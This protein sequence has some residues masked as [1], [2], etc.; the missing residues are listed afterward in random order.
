MIKG[1]R[2]LNYPLKSST[3]S[4]FRVYEALEMTNSNHD[5]VKRNNTNP[6]PKKSNNEIIEEN[7]QAILSGIGDLI[8][9]QNKDLDIIWVNQ[10]VSDLWGDVIGK[11]CY[12]VYK[13]LSEP[14]TDCYV[15][16]I[17]K[18]G[19]S[20]V[21]ERS[22]VLPDGRC[23]DLLITSSPVRDSKGN[24]I[25]IVEVE[26][27][28]TERKNLEQKLKEYTESL[29]K[30]VKKRKQLELQLKE[31]TENL[32]KIV[33]ERTN[34]LSESEE[35]LLGILAGIGDLI[36]IQN[37]EL[38]IIWVNQPI[39]ELWGDIIGKKC[40]TEYK[41]LDAP[42]PDCT[43]E[44]VFN[45]GKKYVSDQTVV[46]LDGSS[47]HTLVTSSPVRDAEGNIVAVV[48]TV[49][50]I[51]DRKQLETALKESERR[52]RGLYESSIDGIASADLNGNFIE[53]NQAYADILGYTKEE[54]LN[55][56]YW[57]LSP[58]KSRDITS[59]IHREQVFNRGYSDEYEK[60]YIRKDGTVF[61]ISIRTWVIKD[62]EGNPTGTWVIVRDITDRKQLEEKIKEYT[63][64]LEKM[65]EERTSELKESEERYRG[66]YDSS[67]DGIASFDLDENILDCNQAFADMLGYTKKELYQKSTWDIVPTKWHNKIKRMVTE[68]TIPRGYS[69]EYETEGIKKDG[70]IFP[71]NVRSMLIQDDEGK[72]AGTWAIVRDITERKQAEGMLKESEERYRGLHESSI[73][74]IV[75]TD[76]QG[77]IVA[78]NQALADMLGY[79][80]AQLRQMNYFELMPSKWH[81]RISKIFTKQIFLRGYSEEFETEGIKKDGTLIPVSTRGWLIKNKE[82]NPLGMWG[83]IRDITE[84]KKVDQMKSQFVNLAAHELRTPLSALKAH[85]ELLDMKSKGMDLPED[86]NRR[87][88]IIMRNAKRLAVLINNLLDYTRLEAGTMKIKK[89][90]GSLDVVVSQVVNEVIPLAKKHNHELNLH[91]PEMLPLIQM[92]KEMIRTVF[93][94][95]ISNAIK[96][97]PDGGKIEVIIREDDDQLHATVKDTGIGIAEEDIE[98]IFH[99]FHVADI[100][101]SVRFKTEFERTGLG[102][103]IIKE[104]V[105]MH[106]GY[107]WVESQIGEG[108]SFHVIL[109]I[110]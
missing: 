45:K 20:V 9:I 7:L 47:M 67:I 89:N 23:I 90:L 30:N 41:G 80:K 78:V 100:P 3:F 62:E 14:C 64:D 87:I 110:D 74:G 102:L 88:G 95:L 104:Y 68:Q 12:E 43:A 29:E 38:D 39:K 49:K 36:T 4:E 108:S 18:K 99:P 84:R 106:G 83:I 85:V 51:T 58:K 57:E 1:S 55:K 61:P 19:K 32:E 73:D 6:Q 53:C 37:K 33:E 16:E 97:T 22:D 40:Y 48:E 54:L 79:K 77:K 63:D 105:K 98:R 109:P 2:Y 65:V 70:T 21:T 71:T 93:N 59:R 13:G 72:P 96:Y 56:T 11:K 10:P 31:Y 25:A 27:D 103:A 75:S 60:E 92:D 34:A 91:T 28:I 17:F 69:D 76:L 46:K 50:D 86:I 15:E 35:K 94:N 5:N 81:D 52:Y 66:L 26:K 101:E 42:C 107:I 82:G 8:T 44:K 24:I